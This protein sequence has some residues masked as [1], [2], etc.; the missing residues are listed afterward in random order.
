VENIK[1]K[2]LGKDKDGQ[3]NDTQKKLFLEAVR[4]KR[5]SPYVISPENWTLIINAWSAI[6]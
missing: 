4:Q 6:W 3:E 2:L 5:L 1:A